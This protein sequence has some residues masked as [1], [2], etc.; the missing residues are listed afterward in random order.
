MSNRAERL[1][2]QLLAFQGAAA[3]AAFGVSLLVDHPL[4]ATHLA[5]A[6][7]VMPLIMSAMLYFIPVL[8]RGA[9]APLG[10]L[11]LPMLALVAGLLAALAFQRGAGAPELFV[12]AAAVALLAALALALWAL[13]RADD[14]VGAPHPCLN[15]YLAALSCLG[16]ALAATLLIHDFSGQYLSIKRLHLH[17]NTLGFI[18]LTALGTLQVLMPTAAGP[19]SSA[20]RRLRGGLRFA[21]GGT[22]LAAI[23]SGWFA[24]LAWAGA[25]LWVV[26]V[27]LTAASWWTRYRPQML[28]WHGAPPLLAAALAG[29][30]LSLI[31][32]LAHGA[33]VYSGR[34]ALGLFFCAFMFPLVTGALTQLLPVWLRPGPHADWQGQARARLGR[35]NGA[36]ALLFLAAGVAGIFEPGAGTFGAAAGLAWFAVKAV[37]LAAAPRL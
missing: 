24:P 12:A 36:A 14:A 35:W 26:P 7:G 19:D 13:W 28:A 16:L 25:A 22:L 20:G 27:A 5:L 34:H 33:A 1:G 23:G 9:A 31:Y 6:V 37:S 2:S 30:A 10:S 8:T 3:V 18:G 11:A 15:W 32:G 17:L 29:F 21:L 4:V